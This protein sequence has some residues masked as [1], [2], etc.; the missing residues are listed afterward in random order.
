MSKKTCAVES[1]LRTPVSAPNG[2]SSREAEDGR[3]S[4]CE[5]HQL[6]FRVQDYVGGVF[7]GIV[8][9]LALFGIPV[10]IPGP[11]IPIAGVG[12]FLGTACGIVIWSLISKR[13]AERI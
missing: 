6:W 1:C 11:D 13:M 9:L 5:P 12:F 2:D 4:L 10:V 7:V 8:A 3:R